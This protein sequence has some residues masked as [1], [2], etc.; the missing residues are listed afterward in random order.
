MNSTNTKRHR[1]RWI[2]AALALAVAA[3]GC[4]M[5]VENPSQI[6]DEDLSSEEAIS[7]LQAGVAYDFAQATANSS[8]GAYLW[9][10]LLTDELTHVGTWVGMRSLSDGLVIDDCAECTTWWSSPAQA[11]WVANNAMTRVEE[12][13][14]GADR[15]PDATLE[16]AEIALYAGHINRIMGG[17]MCNAVQDFQLA[18]N[19][20]YFEE[21]VTHFQRAIAV[22]NNVGAA[23]VVHSAQIGLGNT[24]LNL[25]MLDE[26]AAAVQDVPLAF[27]YEQVFAESNGVSNQFYWWVY[28]R[29]ENSV[30]GTPFQEWGI[31]VDDPTPEGD[32]RVRYDVS[33]EEGEINRGGDNRR[34]FYRQ[35]K[36]PGYGEDIPL[37]KGTEAALIEAEVLLR[38]QGYAARDEV[39]SRINA[40]RSI[41]NVDPIDAATIPDEEALWVTLMKER[42]IELW[43]EGHR[44]PDMRRWALTEPGVEVIPFQVVRD[45]VPGEPAEADEGEQVVTGTDVWQ[46]LG[47]ICIKVSEEERRS[48]QTVR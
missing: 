13:L 10:A 32:P 19:A 20:L 5:D 23:D 3:G 42:G 8:G 31:N 34:P 27:V 24:Y 11:R 17:Y 45:A 25:G 29:N 48:W 28:E 4:G 12:V 44:L 33:M 15:D 22:G 47:D 14:E 36:Y 6:Q 2:P 39:V 18:D 38:Q 21:A 40:V 30:W 16:V 7:A 35:L 43:L 9:G 26:A 1:R 46:E 41:Q 37:T